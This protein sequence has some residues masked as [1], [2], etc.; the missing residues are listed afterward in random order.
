MVNILN[1]LIYS[2][3]LCL[4]LDMFYRLKEAHNIESFDTLF[5][6]TGLKD[7]LLSKNAIEADLTLF[8]MDI[9]AIRTARS[10]GTHSTRAR[11]RTNQARN[12]LYFPFSLGYKYYKCGPALQLGQKRLLSR[13]HSGL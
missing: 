9:S 3:E 12:S 4:V 7:M 11:L 1:L 8:T 5:S 2:N 6:V 13:W 10:K